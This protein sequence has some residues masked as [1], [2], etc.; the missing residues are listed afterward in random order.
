MSAAQEP[1][2]LADEAARLVEAGLE[3]AQRLVAAVDPG[4][5]HVATGAPE[6]AGCPLCRALSALRDPNPET[7]ERLTGMVTDLATLVVTG[8]RAADAHVGAARGAPGPGPTA[9]GDPGDDGGHVAGEH[10]R[11]RPRRR[12]TG[13][14]HID[15]A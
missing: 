12:G 2:P 11:E 1:G 9:Y 15:I 7:A 13:I 3:W 6:C 10:A 5:E 14:E 4:G 8:L